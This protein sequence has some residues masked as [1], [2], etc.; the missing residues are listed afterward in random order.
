[1]HQSYPED[2]ETGAQTGVVEMP[3]RNWLGKS[4][5]QARRLLMVKT[6]CGGKSEV[7]MSVVELKRIC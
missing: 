2:V 4:F 7:F 3:R 1:M 5:E 6:S